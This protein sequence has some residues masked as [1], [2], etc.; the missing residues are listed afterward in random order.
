[1]FEFCRL[2][3]YCMELHAPSSFGLNEF[4]ILLWWYLHHSACFLG[5]RQFKVTKND[6]II[7]HRISADVG[8]KI[9]LEKVIIVTIDSWY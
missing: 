7:I 6:L 9:V 5:G 4:L 3:W 1:M 8:S 2:H